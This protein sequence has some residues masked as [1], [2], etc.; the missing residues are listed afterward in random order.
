MTSYR[1]TDY[2]ERKESIPPFKINIASYRIDD[3][4]YCS[5]DNYDPGAVLARAQGRSREEA[6][7]KAVTLAKERLLRTHI[8][9]E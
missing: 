1:P 8:R 7:Y 9:Q 2:E 4:Y 6:E 3:T 5:V